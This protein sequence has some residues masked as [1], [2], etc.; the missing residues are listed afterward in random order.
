[1]RKAGVDI[2]Q[3]HWSNCTS[4]FRQYVIKATYPQRNLLF[5]QLSIDTYII[6]STTVQWM[7]VRHGNKKPLATA[8]AATEESVQK[9]RVQLDLC[10]SICSSPST[11][12]LLWITNYKNGRESNT[13]VTPH[14]IYA[15]T[16]ILQENLRWHKMKVLHRGML[17]ALM[18]G[19][20]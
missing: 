15:K 1:M 13:E 6:T 9:D 2:R 7:V 4:K 16:K 18:Q 20:R 19:F 17:T 10:S 3:S 14:F 5:S 11:V 12:Y 8:I